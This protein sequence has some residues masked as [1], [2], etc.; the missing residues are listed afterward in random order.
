MHVYVYN[1]L[2]LYMYGSASVRIDIYLSFLDGKAYAN[3]AP[4][5]VTPAPTDMSSCLG[6]NVEV[7]DTA[8]VNSKDDPCAT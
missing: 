1:E 6:C 8:A 5:W 7:G 2:A 4:W 3:A